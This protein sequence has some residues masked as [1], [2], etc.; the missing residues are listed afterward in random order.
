MAESIRLLGGRQLKLQNKREHGEH[1][2][3]L[4]VFWDSNIVSN[5][6]KSAPEN[7]LTIA[8]FP[9]NALA[10][11][12]GLRFVEDARSYTGRDMMK[13]FFPC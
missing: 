10:A 6:R 5:E 4:G 7:A 8:S 1:F 11:V 3:C 9:S 13:M 12:P 2:C